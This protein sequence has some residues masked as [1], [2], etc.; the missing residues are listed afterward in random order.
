M[1]YLKRL[2]IQSVKGRSPSFVSPHNL[3]E[4]LLQSSYVERPLPMDRY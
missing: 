2:T 1:H 4:T 3:G